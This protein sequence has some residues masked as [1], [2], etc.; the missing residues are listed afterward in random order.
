VAIRAVTFDAAGTLIAVAEPVGA[1]YARL[2]ARHGVHVR[3]DDVERRFRA[4]L[5]AAPPLAFPGASP[6][7][8]GT[9]ERAWWYAVVRRAL[10]Q[11]ASGP[12]LDAAFDEL[13]AYYASA[14][15]WRVFAEAPGVLA[16][17]RAQGL[18][19]AVVSNFDARLGPLLDALGVA[20]LLD[21]VVHSSRAGTAKPDPAIFRAA[22]GQLGV[23]PGDALHV[24]DAPIEDVQGA[25]GAGMR[26]V[27]VDRSGG[28]ARVPGEGPDEV[29]VLESLSALPRLL[30][31]P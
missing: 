12:P 28:G 22:L 14:V 8:I 31:E 15:A 10:G 26:A 21:A 4:A 13:F 25:R 19:L 24:G 18:R 1:T 11:T 9:H 7:R 5:A 23:V 17:L 29:H 20:P 6:V 27:L 30:E 2:A 3:A 16:A